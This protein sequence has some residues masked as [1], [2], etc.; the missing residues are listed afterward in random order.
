MRNEFIISK[1][2]ISDSATEI[3]EKVKKENSVAIHIRKGDYPEEW[4][5]KPKFYHLAIKQ[6]Q[7]KFKY[8]KLYIF[9][10][11]LEYAKCTL[12]D[13]YEAVFVSEVDKFSDLEEF[14]IMS[15]CKHQVTSNSTFSWWSAYLNK[16]PEKVVISPETKIFKRSFYP[17][18]WIV[19]DTLNI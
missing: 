18:K 1:L 6:I 14:T 9:C 16:H 19:I 17:K 4:L 12:G 15:S 2:Y 11:D 10:E 7:R 5:V 3:I 8:I 13:E